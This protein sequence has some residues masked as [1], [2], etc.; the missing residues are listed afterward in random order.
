MKVTQSVTSLCIITFQKILIVLKSTQNITLRYLGLYV[1]HSLQTYKCSFGYF[2]FYV[3]Q[4]KQT[5]GYSLYGMTSVVALFAYPIKL[6]IS[7]KKGVT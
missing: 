3:P 4:N 2:S 1:K 5:N 7:T 6:N